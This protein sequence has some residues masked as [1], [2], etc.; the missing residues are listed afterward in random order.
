M[1]AISLMRRCLEAIS[2]VLFFNALP[3]CIR[4][5]APNAEADILKI[6][7][8]GVELLRPAVLTNNTV[9][10]YLPSWEEASNL[11]PTFEL[12]PGA[13]IEPASGVARDFTKPQTYTVTSEDKQ[14]TKEYRVS[15]VQKQPMSFS[16]EHARMHVH[17]G[18]E[19][20]QIFYE[21][22][23]E[24]EPT[25]DWT[26]GNLGFSI[27]N[28]NAPA[29]KYPT[30][31]TEDGYKGK[32]ACLVTQDT[33]VA[34][35]M[36]GMPIAGGNLFIG[37]LDTDNLIGSPLKSTKFGTPIVEEPAYLEGY[38]RY[39]PGPVVTDKKGKK[40]SGTVDT[41]DIY[42]IVF[43]TSNGTEYLDGT[44]ALDHEDLVL[45]ARVEDKQ[46][47]GEWHRFNI[48]FVSHQGK[49]IDPAKLKEG[50]YNYSIVFTSSINAA[51]FEGAVGS[52]LTVDE[53]KIFT[54]EEESDK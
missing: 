13:T 12:T 27:A 14:W 43:D 25:M 1:K 8:K 31:Q 54:K 9:T 50:K 10:L 19:Y 46:P 40:I 49:T 15:V 47:D 34:G 45:V 7:L 39:T 51:K 24:G 30:F 44:N 33:G 11:A 48:P 6:E 23:K 2:L 35:K 29:N 37:K 4:S 22:D 36:F 32:A 38:Y 42:A 52:T 18:K 53:V 41:F 28:S 17:D 3:G 26:S 20:F 5:E 21:V 16:F